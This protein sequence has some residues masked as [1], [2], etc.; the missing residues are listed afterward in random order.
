MK[1]FGETYELY[2]IRANPNKTVPG[3]I[4]YISPEEFE[5]LR[6]WEMID[7]GMSEDIVAKAMTEEGDLITVKTYGLVKEPRKITK[8]IDSSYIREEVPT[9]KNWPENGR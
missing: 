4:W 3:K 8:V 5:Y 2:T 9:K 7:Y 6:E 1:N